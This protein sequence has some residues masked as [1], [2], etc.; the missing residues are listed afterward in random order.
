MRMSGQA[1]YA[2]RKA[3][4]TDAVIR[5]SLETQEVVARMARKAG[6][7]SLAKTKLQAEAEFVKQKNRYDRAYT[8]GK[9]LISDAKYDRWLEQQ[10]KLF[11]TSPAFREVGAAV[12]RGQRVKLPIVVGSLDLC[13][14]K[15]VAGWMEEI[16]AQSGPQKGWIVQPK[17]DGQSLTLRYRNG[18]FDTAWS[19]GKIVNGDSMGYNVSGAAKYIEGVLSRLRDNDAI[20]VNSHEY[21]VRGEVII[22]RSIFKEHYRDN[23]NSDYISPRNMV[24]G[25]VNNIDPL[26]VRQDL[27]RCTFIALMLFRKNKDGVWRRLSSSHKEWVMLTLMGF[28]TAVAPTRYSD[29]HWK[30]R[31]LIQEGHNA[32]RKVLP[33]HE[34]GGALGDLV[35]WDHKPTEAEVVA[36]MQ[37]IHKAV[38]IACDGLVVQPIDNRVFQR[39]GQH[40]DSHPGF[41]R[42]IK[43]APEMQTTM[44]GVVGRI[45][46]KISKRGLLK[47][48]IIF[49]TSVSFE[50]ADVDRCTGINAKFI[51]ANDIRP[52][53]KVKLIRSGEVIPR[54]M[55]IYR[56]GRWSAVV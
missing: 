10:R 44:E 28:T 38:D 12:G 53:R 23:P 39:K 37:D 31:K 7:A 2:Q 47:P 24:V 33:V 55:Q 45:E 11:P 25:L 56:D 16:E 19:R 13:R 21:L 46:W 30:I 6:E 49:R 8:A 22:H 35:Y 54:L 14:P 1:T 34:Y 26:S 42:A 20:D 9:P 29:G 17:L 27:R 41:M 40:L 5:R 32:L 3:V 18:K 36:R 48:V 43:L 4:K 50:G 52:G 51:K 15:D